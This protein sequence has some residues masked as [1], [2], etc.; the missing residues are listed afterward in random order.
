MTVDTPCPR[1]GTIYT[2][3]RELIGK[4]TKCT[5]CGTPFVIDEVP[6]THAPSPAATPSEPGPIP[7]IPLHQLH[8][9]RAIAPP[10]MPPTTYPSGPHSSRAELFGFEHDQSQPRFPVLKLVAR[11]YE[12]LAVIILVIAVIMLIVGI[13]RVIADPRI[14]LSVLASSGM[15]FLWGLTTALMCLFFS[16]ATRLALQVEQNTRETQQACRQLA[17]H[18]TAIQVEK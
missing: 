8:S 9:P 6:A 17:D 16:Q 12:V 5:R 4:R 7:D 10:E 13:V 3:R 15:M 2:V 14:V 18:L 1:C 11:G